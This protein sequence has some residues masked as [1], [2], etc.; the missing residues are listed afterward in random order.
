[1]DLGVETGTGS[2]S[3]HH[4]RIRIRPSYQD[5]DPPIIPGSGSTHHTRVRFR[6]SYQDPDP[7]IIPGSGSAH[8]TRIR[9]HPP[10]QG[11]YPPNIP[12]SGPKLLFA[13][14]RPARSAPAWPSRRRCSPSW[15]CSP[16]C[17]VRNRTC[18]S[19]SGYFGRIRSLSRW[20]VNQDV[21]LSSRGTYIRW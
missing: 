13:G 21:F 7:P 4:T 5:P 12:G 19:G 11:P 10:Y 2:V 16:S 6:P 14:P 15:T 17:P 9:I 20:T 18:P 8:H 1:M 3:A